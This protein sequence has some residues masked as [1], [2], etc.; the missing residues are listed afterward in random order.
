MLIMTIALIGL[1]LTGI[2]GSIVNLR[3][4]GYRRIPTRAKGAR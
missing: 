2:A 1:A 4:D 3:T